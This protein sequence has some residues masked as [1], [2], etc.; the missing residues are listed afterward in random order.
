MR[1]V[2]EDAQ[3]R[4]VVHQRAQRLGPERFRRQAGQ[5]RLGVGEQP[6]DRLLQRAL[7]RIERRGLVFE[8]GVVMLQPRPVQP[9]D[10]RD[11]LD[12][13]LA[14]AGEPHM[15]GSAVDEG[16]ALVR[17]T[18]LQS[19]LATELAGQPLVGRQAVADCAF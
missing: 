8:T 19:H 3:A 2:D 5:L 17:P 11:P 1:A 18:P 12:P 16:S 14:P 9:V 13:S 7:R 15:A 4:A 10:L 6:V